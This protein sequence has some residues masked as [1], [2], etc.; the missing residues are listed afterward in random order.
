MKDEYGNL[1][2][3]VIDY[4]VFIIRLNCSHKKMYNAS[5]YFI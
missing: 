3:A 5:K 2:L 1:N 4:I